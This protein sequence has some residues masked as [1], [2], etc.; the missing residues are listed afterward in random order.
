MNPAQQMHDRLSGIAPATCRIV[1]ERQSLAKAST[2]LWQTRLRV[3]GL[4]ALMLGAAVALGAWWLPL[5]PLPLLALGRLLAEIDRNRQAWRTYR[6]AIVSLARWPADA[7]AQ[8]DRLVAAGADL[9]DLPGDG[10]V[11]LFVTGTGDD[12]AGDTTTL[13]PAHP[14]AHARLALSAYAETPEGRTTLARLAA[15][16]RRRFGP[17]PFLFLRDDRGFV[18]L[19]GPDPNSGGSRLLAIRRIPSAGP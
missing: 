10:P 9:P 8:A 6:Q 1:D 3:L 14:S 16:L 17:P 12:P 13:L 4:A 15:D 2:L 18:L 7:V 11:L 5:A 19:L